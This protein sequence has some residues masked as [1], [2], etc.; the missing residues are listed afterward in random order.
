MDY[1][2]AIYV[3]CPNCCCEL[4]RSLQERWHMQSDVKFLVRPLMITQASDCSRSQG[5]A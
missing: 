2:I 5:P 3:A 4:A 1:Q